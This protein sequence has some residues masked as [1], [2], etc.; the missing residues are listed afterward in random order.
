MI[1]KLNLVRSNPDFRCGE[2]PIP[3]CEMH[4]VQYNVHFSIQSNGESAGCVSDSIQS[5]PIR[6]DWTG[7]NSAD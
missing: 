4:T 2:T 3:V 5:H 6:L 7:L 1:K